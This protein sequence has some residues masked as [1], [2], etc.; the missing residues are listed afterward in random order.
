MY[1]IMKA[2]YIQPVISVLKVYGKEF[3]MQNEV[4][5]GSKGTPASSGDGDE[6]DDTKS[7]GM[8]FDDKDINYGNIW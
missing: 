1:H 6:P 3:I 2:E 5:V 7:R 8:S 4:V